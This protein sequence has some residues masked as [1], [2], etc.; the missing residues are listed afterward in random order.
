MGT[1]AGIRGIS[2]DIH[3]ALLK[4]FAVAGLNAAL[5]S[6]AKRSTE[7]AYRISLLRTCFLKLSLGFRVSLPVPAPRRLDDAVKI[8]VLRPEAK[9][10]AGEGCIRNQER[11]VAGAAWRRFCL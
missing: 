10:S 9:L 1:S 5:K 7:V 3:Y 8:R 2:S 6:L 4:V 11:G